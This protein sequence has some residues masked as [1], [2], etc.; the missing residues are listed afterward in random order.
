[1]AG[2]HSRAP[3]FHRAERYPHFG[4]RAAPP[5]REFEECRRSG[6]SWRNYLGG[7]GARP[8]SQDSRADRLGRSRSQ[9]GGRAFGN[10]KAN[11]LLPDA[12]AWYLTIQARSPS[13]VTRFNRRMKL[14]VIDLTCPLMCI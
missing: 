4:Q 14:P 13:L 5:P 6:I 9:W 10:E 1:M 8:H 7:R 2:Q 11:P 3:K 12:K